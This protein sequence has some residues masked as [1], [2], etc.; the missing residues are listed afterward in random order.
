MQVA[1]S[2]SGMIDMSSIAEYDDATGPAQSATGRELA[3]RAQLA[4]ADCTQARM[5]AL[6]ETSRRSPRTHRSP[7]TIDALERQQQ[8]HPCIAHGWL[9]TG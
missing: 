6:L 5:A 9:T 8:R 4:G 3:A 7:T 1:P 2:E